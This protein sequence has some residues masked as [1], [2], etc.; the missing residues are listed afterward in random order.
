MAFDLRLQTAFECGMRSS[1][2]AGLVGALA[3]RL[4]NVALAGDFG[5]G[6]AR[7]CL[8]ACL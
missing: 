2:D 6:R 7:P 4:G 8:L 1:L 5:S 3:F